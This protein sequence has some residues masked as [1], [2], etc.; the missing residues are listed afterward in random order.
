M[1][2]GNFTFPSTLACLEQAFMATWNSAARVWVP[3]S[4]FCR[5]RRCFVGQME[6]KPL[7]W[8]EV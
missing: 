5:R 3:V 8:L 7:P 1:P 4:L 2:K 6:I